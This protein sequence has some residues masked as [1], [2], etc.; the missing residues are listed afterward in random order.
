MQLEDIDSELIE[1]QDITFENITEK[2]YSIIYAQSRLRDYPT[3]DE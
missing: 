3:R 2:D 1:P